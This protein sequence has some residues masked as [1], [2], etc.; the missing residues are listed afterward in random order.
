[1]TQVQPT[2][3]SAPQDRTLTPKPNLNALLVLLATIQAEQEA[4]AVCLARLVS[5]PPALERLFVLHVLL[6]PILRLQPLARAIS[7]LW[8]H[9]LPISRLPNA[10]RVQLDFMATKW[11]CLGAYPAK[12]VP[13]CPQ[14]ARLYALTVRWVLTPSSMARQFAVHAPRVHIKMLPADPHAA[15]VQL[16]NRWLLSVR[17]RVV[18]ALWVLILRTLVLPSV[19]LVSQDFMPNTVKVPSARLARRVLL[20]MVA[21]RSLVW[22]ANLEPTPT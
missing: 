3:F 8:A 17:P 10:P 1:V 11:A 7:A 21:V 2:V 13:T 6:V 16:A 5:M 19:F 14:Q 12:L 22:A 20:L 15:C 9:L 4:W 18:T